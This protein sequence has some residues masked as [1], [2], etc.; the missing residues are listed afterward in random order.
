VNCEARSGYE[1]A[2][3][4]PYYRSHDGRGYCIF[5]YP[6][7][8]KKEEFREAIQE[9]IQRGSYDFFEYWF[10]DEF[11]NLKGASVD[12]VANFTGATFAHSVD[13]TGTKFNRGVRFEITTLLGNSIFKRARFA[14]CNFD[15]VAFSYGAEFDDSLFIADK[16]AERQDESIA[17]ETILGRVARFHNIYIGGNDLSFERAIFEIE[18][19]FQLIYWI[20]GRCI[21]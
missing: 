4:E 16:D 6:V 14:G 11:E 21:G 7:D 2:C 18:V 5:H 10:P 15:S 13:F 9:K 8:D 3:R 1:E 17:R 19:R 12:E 20:F